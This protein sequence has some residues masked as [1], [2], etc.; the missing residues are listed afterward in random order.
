MVILS[1][2]GVFMGIGGAILCGVTGDWSSVGYA[3]SG[4]GWA[5]VV[6]MDRVA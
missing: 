1:G 5:A 2:F 3:I 4:A 6:L